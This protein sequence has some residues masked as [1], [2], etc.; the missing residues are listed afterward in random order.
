MKVAKY[1]H[2]VRHLRPVQVYARLWR[3]VYRP[4]PDTSPVPLRKPSGAWSMCT[5]HQP[6]LLGPQTFR[7]LNETREINSAADWNSVSSDNL[8]LYNLHYFGDLVAEKF[9]ERVTWHRKL[10]ER[11]T[12]ENRPGSGIGWQSYPLSQRIVN[13]IKWAVAGGELSPALE[14]SLAI[15]ASYLSRRLEY[16]LLGN[17]LLANAKALIFAGAFFSGPEADRWLRIGLKLLDS[18]MRE[19]FLADGGH[20]ERSPMY[21]SMLTEDLLDLAQLRSLYPEVLEGRN[22]QVLRAIDPCPMLQWLQ[23]MTHPD[24]GFAFFND[25]AFGIAPSCATLFAYARNLGVAMTDRP[26]AAIESLPHSGYVRLENGP[27]VLIA[28]V[29]SIGP[30]YLPGHAHAGTLSFELSLSGRRVIVNS[31]VSCYGET[32]ERLRQRGTAAHTTVML[33]GQ[34]SSEVWGNFRVGRRA[35]VLAPRTWRENHAVCAEAGHDGYRRSP[36]RPIHWRRWRMEKSTVCVEDRVEGF[37]E[38]LVEI[39]FYLHP[40]LRPSLAENGVVSIEDQAGRRICF[41][42]T[43]PHEVLTLEHSTWHPEFGCS[44]PSFR[45][46]FRKAQR[47]PANYLFKIDH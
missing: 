7:F 13:W 17:H 8:W 37:G 3:Y 34:N 4:R 46:A 42:S 29:G 20:F 23:V 28:D 19:Q 2:T 25:A 32:A 31:G 5:G 10:L 33:D 43:A 27:A 36:G 12:A 21:H 45:I 6:Q 16:H 18:E 30:N 24:G 14:N 40:G 44:V 38:H 9:S 22:S 35:R 15:Q 41:I 11:W 1:F 47:L 39:F 26:L